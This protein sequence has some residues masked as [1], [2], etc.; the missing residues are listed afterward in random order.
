MNYRHVLGLLGIAVAIAI[1]A[2]QAG[3]VGAVCGIALVR[4]TSLVKHP[5]EPLKTG[6]GELDGIQREVAAI[7]DKV[8]GITAAHPRDF[9]KA[10]PIMML[11]DGTTVR[12]WKNLVGVDHVFLAN[13]NGQMIRGA[14]V[15]WIHNQ[16]LQQAIAKIRREFS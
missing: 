4:L 3:W 9:E 13:K 14:Y 1:L 16:G 2:I 6:S 15:G 10:L 8:P 7:L 5:S 12:T 11:K